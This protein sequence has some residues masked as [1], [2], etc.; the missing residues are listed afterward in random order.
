MQDERAPV[1]LTYST[2]M[3]R[4]PMQGSV[5]GCVDVTANEKLAPETTK[6]GTAAVPTF[7]PALTVV[8]TVTSSGSSGSW[9]IWSCRQ[10]HTQGSVSW[11]GGRRKRSPTH[12]HTAMR[13]SLQLFV[14]G[15]RSCLGC[16]CRQRFKSCSAPWGCSSTLP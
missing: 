6:F 3:G 13:P 7:E 4:L 5:S 14:L 8:L 12:L 2:C 15:A 11:H 9:E 16:E 10:H 1:L